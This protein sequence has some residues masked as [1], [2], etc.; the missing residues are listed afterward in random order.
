MKLMN[1]EKL[2]RMADFIRRYIR[3]HGGVSPKFSEIIAYMGMNN[4]VG[5]RYLTTL[6][7]RGEIEYSGKDSL[8]ISGQERMQVPF[9]SVAVLGGIPCG[10]PEEHTEEAEHFIALPQ[11]W[12]DGSCY[13]LRAEGDSM[14]G[15]GIEDGDLVLIRQQPTARVGQIVVALVDDT[16]TTLKRY[17]TD[18]TTGEVILHPENPKYRDIR[19]PQVAVQGVALKVIKDLI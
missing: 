18:R 9:R 6:A 12:A 13:L 17:L 16:S 3:E 15:A 7:D 10:A 4:S 11:E 14:I 19:R 1:E 2:S 5:Y 8:R